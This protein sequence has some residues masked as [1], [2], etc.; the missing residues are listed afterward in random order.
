M[1]GSLLA[2]WEEWGGTSQWHKTEQEVKDLTRNI[3]DIV[4]F[5]FFVAEFIC[6][7]QNVGWIL[8]QLLGLSRRSSART[9]WQNEF[10]LAE[11]ALRFESGT[12]GG[13]FCAF[14]MCSHDS[15]M[16]LQTAVWISKSTDLVWTGQH[17]PD[18]R[19]LVIPV[20]VGITLLI[21]SP[22]CPVLCNSWSI[23][24]RTHDIP[25]ASAAN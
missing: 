5:C 22:V 19:I 21:L 1:K 11:E 23:I 17:G 16:I 20:P 6:L 8:S 24:C 15:N 12:A 25:S 7:C 3:Q 10:T 2:G 4:R 18:W 14:Y 9:L 13:F